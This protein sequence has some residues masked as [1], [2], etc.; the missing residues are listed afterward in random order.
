M[1]RN[2]RSRLAISHLLPLLVIVPL[3]S[4]LLLYL[5]E[6]RYVLDDAAEELAG[7]GEL[8]SQ[9]YQAEWSAL[10]DPEQAQSLVARLQIQEKVFIYLIDKRGNVIVRP[11]VVTAS[12]QVPVKPPDLELLQRALSGEVARVRQGNAVDVAVPVSNED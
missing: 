3:L 1:L 4:L 2:L 10:Q 7:Q 6:T 8:I 12:A 11:A 9:L 5:I